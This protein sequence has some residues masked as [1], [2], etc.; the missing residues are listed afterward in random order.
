MAEQNIP[1]KKGF[2]G[3]RPENVMDYVDELLKNSDFDQI[4]ISELEKKISD[5]DS[6]IS[7]RDEQI[8]LKDQRIAELESELETA[9]A[10]AAAGV[11]CAEC[12]V[13]K[14]AEALLGETLFDVKRFTLYLVNDAKEKAHTTISDAQ[15]TAGIVSE[16]AKEILYNVDDISTH[17]SSQIE[18]LRESLS[19]LSSKLDEFCTGI[20][21]TTDAPDEP[22]RIIEHDTPK[23]E[24][25]IL[26]GMK[27][28]IY[29]ELPDDVL[30]SMRSLGASDIPE[31]DNITST[32]NNSVAPVINETVPSDNITAEA[33]EVIETVQETPVEE[34][35]V[36]NESAEI[37]HETA[38]ETFR[39][40]AVAESAATEEIKHDFTSG[41]EEKSSGFVPEPFSLNTESNPVAP[42]EQIPVNIIR[43]SEAVMPGMV[44]PFAD[45]FGSEY[46]TEKEPVYSDDAPSAD[47]PAFRTNPIKED[48][49][50]F[51]SG[52][53][54]SDEDRRNENFTFVNSFKMKPNLNSSDE[55]VARDP[56]PSD[57]E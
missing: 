25:D 38:Q 3:F 2:F 27:A 19:G 22:V 48:L 41:P 26:A 21:P 18:E 43:N 47:A 54:E 14:K 44:S 53:Q 9:K 28:E 12:D 34:V 20:K 4:K 40:E 23:T 56:L 32:D 46:Q 55:P 30:R 42:E 37:P 11:R 13:Q 31:S 16:R 15:G 10:N 1:F 24:D 36:Q 29:N 49:P 33:D 17:F 35:S 6:E 50:V 8:S 51:D 45:L 57:F 5:F 39:E 52:K 7:R